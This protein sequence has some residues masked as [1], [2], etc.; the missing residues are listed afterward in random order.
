MSFHFCSH[1]WE[2]RDLEDGTS[3]KLGNRDLSLASIAG[4]VDDLFV[5]VEE[6]GR[7]NLDLDFADIGLASSTVFGKLVELNAK[8]REHGGRLS[9]VNLNASLRDMLQRL[10]LAHILNVRAADAAVIG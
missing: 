10:E 7:P 1:S 9:L 5:L 2:V 8:L 4:V 3:V 6:S